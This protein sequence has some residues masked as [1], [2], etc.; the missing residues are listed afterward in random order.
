M[1]IVLI[2]ANVVAFI[3]MGLFFITSAFKN[4]KLVL[5]VQAIGHVFLAMS[6]F[7]TK[8]YSTIAQE[9]I[10][11]IR[12]VGI[13]TKKAN[14]WFKIIILI[15]IV[16]VGVCLNYF[17][18]GKKE[19]VNMV[20]YWLGY[21]VIFANF[22][23]TIDVFYNNK[24]VVTF[25]LISA[26]SN[27]SWMALFLSSQLYTSGIINGI[28]GLINVIVGIILFVKYKKGITDRMGNKIK[29]EEKSEIEQNVEN[30]Y[31][32]LKI[33]NYNDIISKR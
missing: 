24:S 30:E 20:T 1:D 5:S 29:V 17:I 31:F 23:W 28:S 15:L 32:C 10:C 14:K 27:F 33:K 19:D 16:V 26:L 22:I 3:G 9:A 4:K 2:I 18:D 12:D 6:E 8:T 25:K 7:L 11:L 21:L 13:I